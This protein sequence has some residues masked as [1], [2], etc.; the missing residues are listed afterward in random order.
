M[1]GGQLATGPGRHADHQRNIELPARHVEYG[2]GVVDN[3]I[4]RQ[5]AEIDRHDLHDRTHSAHRGAYARADES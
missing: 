2:R 4:Q 3:L 1:L 5:Q